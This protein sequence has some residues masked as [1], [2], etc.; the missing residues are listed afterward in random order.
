MATLVDYLQ[1]YPDGA[2]AAMQ[3][4]IDSVRR[5]NGVLVTLWHNTRLGK[6]YSLICTDLY[7][8][9]MSAVGSRVTLYRAILSE[10]QKID[11]RS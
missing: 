9:F 11:D 4:L 6:A 2:T 7:Q 3:A 8:Q 5:R 1:L 10:V